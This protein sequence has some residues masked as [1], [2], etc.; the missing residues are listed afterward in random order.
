MGTVIR[1]RYELGDRL[2]RGG[3]G[4]VWAARDLQL[5]RVVAVKLLRSKGEGG[6]QDGGLTRLERRFAREAQLTA[7][8]GHP[9]VPAVFET[10]RH[11]GETLYIA[12]E[13]VDG[14]TLS[15]RLRA[16]GPLP[17][18]LAA[19]V[20]VQT[21]DVLAHAHR[22]GV[23]H[24]DLKP[25]NLMLTGNNTV[26][27]LDFGIA[28]ALEPDPDEPRLTGT[29]EVPGTPGFISPEQGLGEPATTRSDLYAL[30]C[31]LYEA[32]TGRPP[33]EIA[34]GASPFFLVYKHIQDK[35]R[36]VSELRPGVPHIFADLVMRLL[37]KDPGDRPSVQE[38]QTVARAWTEQQPPLITD[39]P[40]A[41]PR[42]ASAADDADPPSAASLTEELRRL[43][44]R[45][46]H[47]A[48][49]ALIDSHLRRT[50]RPVDDPEL[51]PL[52][53][54][55][56]E[57]LLSCEDFTQAYDSYFQLGGALRR[58][59]P[60][61]DRDVLACRAGAAKCLAELGRTTEALHEFEAML[62]VQQHAFGATDGRV[63]DTRYEIASL[64][65]RGGQVRPARDQ[66]A[67]LRDDQRRVLP[68]SDQ[69]HTKVEELIARF[70]QFLAA[71]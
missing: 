48:A 46:E 67:A 55:R 56:C 59:R 13:L 43:S 47:A 22:I 18:R 52:R 58:S 8:I 14:Q 70:D 68:A 62:P 4:E 61:T 16:Q 53:L 71:T 23:V 12:M 50:R 1:E 19:L 63:F 66:L 15:A 17:V 38:V 49:A 60:A 11:D 26:K 5:D 40:S 6:G 54:T 25:S 51:L 69:R 28:S 31:V 39:A 65:A 45:G 34:P 44:G 57:L 29:N 7:R 37:A 9:G 33:F 42:P 36:P 21:A 3:M 10:G 2:G 64:V 27:V 20:A 41:L 24:R 32:L 35:P 30:G